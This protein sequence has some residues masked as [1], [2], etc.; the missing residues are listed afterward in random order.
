MAQLEVSALAP[1]DGTIRSCAALLGVASELQGAPQSFC[2]GWS[3]DE[4]LGGRAA[5]PPL[6]RGLGRGYDHSART[7]HCETQLDEGPVGVLRVQL[8]EEQIGTADRV[9]TVLHHRV[10]TGA[11]ILLEEQD[12]AWS[13]QLTR[14]RSHATKAGCAITHFLPRERAS[15]SS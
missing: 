2:G 14:A 10:A 5:K 12:W 15:S 9:E 6:G 13:S 8:R 11:R 3:R 4:G 1:V 7:P